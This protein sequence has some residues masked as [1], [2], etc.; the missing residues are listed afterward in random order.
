MTRKIVCYK[1]S[2]FLDKFPPSLKTKMDK[3]GS[4]SFYVRGE[5]YLV[6]IS[7]ASKA[8]RKPK[9]KKRQ[10]GGRKKKPANTL[11]SVKQCGGK[12]KRVSTKSASKKKTSRPKKAPKKKRSAKK[13]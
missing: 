1:G 9:R 4:G 13:K 5:D 7:K 6:P 3:F 11:K 10:T 8:I 2:C 12:R